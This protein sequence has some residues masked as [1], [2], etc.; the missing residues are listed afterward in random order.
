[1][2][3]FLS[4]SDKYSTH[5]LSRGITGKPSSLTVILSMVLSDLKD[6]TELLLFIL[7]AVLDSLQSQ[8]SLPSLVAH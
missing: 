8:E 7:E 1:M 2:L 4:G 5:L 3:F 6:G